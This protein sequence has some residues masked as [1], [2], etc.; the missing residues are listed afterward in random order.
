[1]RATRVAGSIFMNCS[2]LRTIWVGL[3]L[4]THCW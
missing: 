3:A 2:V 1:M 4:P